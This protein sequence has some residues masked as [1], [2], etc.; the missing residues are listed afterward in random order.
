[1]ERKDYRNSVDN[2]EELIIVVDSENNII[3]KTKESPLSS[4]LKEVFVKGVSEKG[5]SIY[6]NQLGIGLAE[7][8]KVLDIKYYYGTEISKPAKA[9]LEK[10]NAKFDY[11]NVIELVQSSSNPGN[12]CPVEA[13]LNSL[14]TFE[15]R[16]EFLKKKATQK[17]KSCSVNFDK[18]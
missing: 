4:F 7:L 15:E 8:S 18:K 3:F 17:G 5:L 13:R 9:I 6:A 2:K 12:T 16:V 10:E 1:M 11:L 14:S